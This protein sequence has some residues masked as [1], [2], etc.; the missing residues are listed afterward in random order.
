MHT[1]LA[2][3]Q[4]LHHY[5]SLWSPNKNPGY[6]IQRVKLLLAYLWNPEKTYQCIHIA[7]TSGKGTTAWICSQLLS[8]IGKKVGL[9]M[10][11]HI[12]DIRERCLVD[13]VYLT[14]SDFVEY[15]NTIKQA[16]ETVDFWIYGHP[17]YFEIMVSLALYAF[18]QQKVDIAVL[19]TGLGGRRDATNVIE[20]KTC[21]ITSI[22]LDHTEIL[23]DTLTKITTEKAM[24]V[25]PRN[26]CFSL[27]QSE[28]IDTTLEQVI[29]DQ[30]GNL[31]R[32]EPHVFES[33]NYSADYEQMNLNLAYHS[34]VHLYPNHKLT[35][36]N[37]LKTLS[38]LIGRNMHHLIQGKEVILDG[39]HNPQKMEYFLKGIKA[40][41]PD[42]ALTSI[43]AF[44][45]GKDSASMLAIMR[46]YIDTIIFTEFF[47]QIHDFEIH[48]QDS[49]L[50]KQ[51]V[52]KYWFETVYSYPDWHD[53]IAKGIEASWENPL[54]ITGSFYLLGEILS[55]DFD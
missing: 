54:I 29:K 9:S 13:N 17:S 49:I 6:G 36:K 48:S 14:E 10:S 27:H 2:V 51:E 20:E 8:T 15:A 23:W 16:I 21:I 3:E 50:L 37:A 45:K 11:P 24:I 12:L 28:E 42:Q 40:K 43:V 53:A 26:D 46:K 22:G 18:A 41:F 35:L 7:G 31:H 4:R 52:I 30:W 55:K 44:K 33:K 1:K 34:I 5:H 25:H 38:S 19:E 32:I 39:A 47:L